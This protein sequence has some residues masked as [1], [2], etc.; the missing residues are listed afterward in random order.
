M[1]ALQVAINRTSTILAYGAHHPVSVL[2]KLNVSDLAGNLFYNLPN[3]SAGMDVGSTALNAIS[4]NGYLGWG[5]LDGGLDY[6]NSGDLLTPAIWTA[7]NGAGQPVKPNCNASGNSS[8]GTPEA[9]V[10]QGPD[11]TIITGWFT[12]TIDPL[13]PAVH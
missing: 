4:I 5:T 7:A 13:A 2:S 8:G 12:S 3:G 1:A 9:H 11:I 10:M 6:P